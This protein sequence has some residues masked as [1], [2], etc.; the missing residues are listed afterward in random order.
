M[1]TTM[2]IAQGNVDEH[3]MIEVPE[4]AVLYYLF[5]FLSRWWVCIWSFWI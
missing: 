4:Q 3:D 2:K 1:F 5:Y